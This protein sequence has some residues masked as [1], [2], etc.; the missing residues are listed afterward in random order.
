MVFV[1]GRK[2]HLGDG[3]FSLVKEETRQKG[4]GCPLRVLVILVWFGHFMKRRWGREF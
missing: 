1:G 2:R 4:K 3:S